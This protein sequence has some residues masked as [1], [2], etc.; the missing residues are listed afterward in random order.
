MIQIVALLAVSW[1]IIWLFERG[2]LSVLG[3]IPNL[4]RVKY[5]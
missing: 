4:Q 2:N 3:L 5:F 1:L